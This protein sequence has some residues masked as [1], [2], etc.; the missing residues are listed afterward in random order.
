MTDQPPAGM[1]QRALSRACDIEAQETRATL[2]SFL[3]VLI[4]M[5]S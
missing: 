4:L 3:L 5:G 1:L 2:A